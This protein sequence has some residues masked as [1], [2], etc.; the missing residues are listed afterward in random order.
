MEEGTGIVGIY[1]PGTA[2]TDE[3]LPGA[4]DGHGM[5]SMMQIRWIDGALYACGYGA[6]VFR[7]THGKWEIFNA[8]LKALDFGDYLKQGMSVPEALDA[9][10]KTQRNIRTL[11][12]LSQNNL[13]CAGWRGI[14]FHYDG[15]QWHQLES[16][17]N[18]SLNRIKCVDD[19]ST[20]IVGDGG[21]L[22]KG[23]VSGFQAIPTGIADDFVS[24][25]WFNGKLYVGGEKGLYSLNGQ[26]L[27]RIDVGQKGD[28]RC[29]ALDAHDGQLLAVSE[30]WFLAFDG[31]DWK[32]IDDPDNVP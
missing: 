21:V 12:G 20:Y 14:I 1:W 17:T 8:G 15:N 29:I 11:D 16:P 26:T 2:F 9:E 24:V 31:Q 27:H 5:P 10:K 13:F 7:R 4:E 3:T 28:F 22:L 30:R 19:N 6:N 23:N 18:T 25:T 32:R